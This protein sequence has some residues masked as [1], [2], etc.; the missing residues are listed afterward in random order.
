MMGRPAWLSIDEAAVSVMLDASLAVSDVI[1]LEEVS[2][3]KNAEY[4]NK[5][6]YS[7]RRRYVAG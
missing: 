6:A 7:C 5:L 2:H 4:L 1:K 3:D